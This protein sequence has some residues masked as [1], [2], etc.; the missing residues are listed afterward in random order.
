[1]RSILLVGVLLWSIQTGLA[2]N[3]V[4]IDSNSEKG[5]LYFY[6]GWNRGWY[7]NS[8]ISF[9][10]SNYDFELTDVVAKDRP[11]EFAF[12]P[13]FHPG[14][15]T[16]PQTNFRIGY[17]LSPNWDI[18]FGVDH[19][20][21]V[22]Q[23]NQSVGISG[24]IENS[25]TNYDGVYS[26]DLVLIKDDFL[27]F[28]HT[29]GLNY[30]NVELR[31]F[32]TLWDLNKV[33]INLTEGFGL[34]FLL[35][36][37]NTTLLSKKKHDE[38]HLSGFGLGSMIG[39]NVSFFEHF[40]IQTEFKGGYINMPDIRTTMDTADRASQ[41]FFFTQLNIVFGASINTKKRFKSNKS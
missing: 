17:F 9:S 30:I 2:Q 28:E 22:V 34:G 35:P 21:Y 29:D 3:T 14:R 4:S 12:D 7:S 39:L 20:K 38:F 18:S 23:T 40:F 36:K 13:Y 15:F 10:G 25:N 16:I 27:K 31:R 1:M 6:W 37:T 11:S 8:D 32:D 33:K 19:M 24:F 26:D 5:S 41:S